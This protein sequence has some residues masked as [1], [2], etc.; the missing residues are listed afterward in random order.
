MPGPSFPSVPICGCGAAE[1][2]SEDLE[3]VV[4]TAT[5]RLLIALEKVGGKNI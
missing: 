3:A 1:R 5:E 2:G 4:S